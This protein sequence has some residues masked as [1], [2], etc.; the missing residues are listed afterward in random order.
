NRGDRSFTEVSSQLGMVSDVIPYVAFGA[1]WLDADND[2]WLDLMF[3][4]GHTADNIADTGQGY[5]YREPTLLFK[6]EQGGR[7]VRV[8][9]RDLD[10]PIVGRGL[11][12]GDYDNDGRMDALVVDSEGE[13]MLLHNETPKSGHW[14]SL[15]L[16]GTKGNRDA[17]GAEATVEVGGRKLIR[18]CH[19]DGSYL[20]SSDP[21]VHFG[22]GSSSIAA[23]ITIRC[24]V[25]F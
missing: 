10:R 4:N 1:K 23:K 22:L 25:G 16:V 19:A 8:R 3:T 14:L 6:N 2:G 15:R 13:V 17:Y 7:F 20:S 12:I 24:P 21:R 5:T 18:H 11:A 9:L